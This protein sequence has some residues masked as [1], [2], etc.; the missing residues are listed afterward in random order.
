LRK[1]FGLIVALLL[2]A[3]V[4]G[5]AFAGD[6]PP[7]KVAV[8][9]VRVFKKVFTF[10]ANAM[11]FKTVDLFPR[12]QGKILKKL[13]VDVGDRVRKGQLLALLDDEY[14]RIRY[15]AALAG[16]R[17]AEAAL[18][19]AKVL[20]DNARRDYYRVKQLYSKKVVSKQKLDHAKAQY[21][22]A[23][24][25]LRLA[26]EKLKSAKVA[27]SEANLLLSYHKIISPV[28]GVVAMKFLDE[29]TMTSS[30][31]PI[32]R[33]IQDDPIKVQGG[34]PQEALS[35]VRIGQEVKVYVDVYPNKVFEGR[36]KIISP[37]VDPLS[38][39]F[40]VEAWIDN[41]E[42]LLKVG[43]FLRAKLFAGKRKVLAIPVGCIT[44]LNKVFVY[45]GGVVFE[46]R[47]KLGEI[48]GNYIEVLSGLKPGEKVVLQPTTWLKN[49]MH[50]EV[51]D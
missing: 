38:R 32:L 23:F 33:L 39:T 27:L 51:A 36:V 22:Q 34:L 44:S 10:T 12:V 47:L 45:S 46:R 28:D 5:V 26:E 35:Y 29:G 13:F 14:A 4:Q 43:M 37:L 50:V 18:R 42:H 19:Q 9:K 49:G 40:T 2:L 17:A 30:A 3:S 24:A 11:A 8:A 31:K 7:V 48:Q 25:G 15:Q 41:H 21:E 20:A 1:G 16:V 6:S